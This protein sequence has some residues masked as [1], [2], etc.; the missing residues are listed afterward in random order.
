[1]QRL[2]APHLLARVVR[3]HALAELEMSSLLDAAS[4]GYSAVHNR[5]LLCNALISA[6][7]ESDAA[8][9]ALPAPLHAELLAYFCL[10]HA[11]EPQ[12]MLTQLAATHA[13]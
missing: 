4:A 13:Q 11:D 3:F 8:R 10:L 6:L 2:P 1:M 5:S 7:E 9:G 12:T